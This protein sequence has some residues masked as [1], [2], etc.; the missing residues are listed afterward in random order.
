MNILIRNGMIL[1]GNGNEPFRADVYLSGNRIQDIGCLADAQADLVLNAE[2]LLVTPGFVDIHRHPD[3]SVLHGGFGEGELAQ[4]ITTVIGGNCGL[5]PVPMRERDALEAKA[6]LEPCLGAADERIFGSFSSYL[7]AVSEAKP[8]VN[9][10]LHA[11]FGAIRIC[12]KG[13]EKKP[14]TEAEMQDARA[15][16]REAMEAGAAGISL[17]V[18]YPPE[19]YTSAEEYHRLLS[20]ASSYGRPLCCHIRGEGASLTASVQEVLAIAERVELPVHISHFKSTGRANW[21]NEIHRAID[22]IEKARAKGQDVTADFYPYTAGASTLLSLV[23]PWILND[24]RGELW[25]ELSTASGKARMRDAVYLKQNHWDNMVQDIGWE[26]IMLAS[27]EGMDELAGLDMRTAAVRMGFDDPSDA[28]CDIL[29]H[30]QGKAGVVLNSMCEEDVQT[31]A[32]L[33]YTFL[34]S[35]AL[36]GGGAAHPRQKGAFAAFLQNFVP[37]P[38]SLPQA[39]RKM[40]SMPADRLGM[41]QIGRIEPGCYADLNLFSVNEFRANATYTHPHALASGMHCVLVNGRIAWQ[42]EKMTQEAAGRV[43]RAE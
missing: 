33:P 35:D 5:C 32:Q 18:M 34:I 17:G 8:H 13:F 25:R 30:T 16:L 22:V 4:G 12:V 37:N 41:K 43:I 42:D 10:G 26:R 14:F 31:I 36:Y 20:A 27:A 1:D 2:G 38:L 3:L 19:C 9:M 29:V 7:K 40:T 15:L 39:I 11:A 28:M 24:D 6:F 21:Q 23:P